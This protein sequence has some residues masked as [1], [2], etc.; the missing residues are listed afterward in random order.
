MKL[1]RVTYSGE[2]YVLA[3]SPEAAERTMEREIRVDGLGLAV[4]ASGE[5][6]SLD[7][8]PDEW[9][10]ALPFGFLGEEKSIR[11]ILEGT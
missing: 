4:E 11:E 10:D 1:Y 9:I 2:A 3:D 6:T 8:I 7:G 5:V